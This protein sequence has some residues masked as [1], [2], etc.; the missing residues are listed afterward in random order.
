[1]RT[2]Q[3]LA[4][5]LMERMKNAMKNAAPAEPADRCVEMIPGKR[6]RADRGGMVTIIRCSQYRVVFQ[7]EGYSGECELNRREFDRKFT[8]VT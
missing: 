8:E 4:S 6:Y 3:E 2:H 1:M 5:A 7:R